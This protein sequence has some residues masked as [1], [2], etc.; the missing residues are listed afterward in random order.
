MPSVG[1]AGFTLGS[2]SGW[3]E[4]KLGLAADALRSAHV[5]TAGGALVTASADEHA[6][7]FWALRGGGPSFGVAVEL[8]LALQPVG[9]EI[10]GGLIGWPMARA[11]EVGGDLRRADGGRPGRPRGRTRAAQRAAGAVRAGGAARPGR[12]WPSW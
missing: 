8:E 5:V 2:G 6:D 10:R 11:A 7:L 9:P 12:S 4:R 1:V 3:L